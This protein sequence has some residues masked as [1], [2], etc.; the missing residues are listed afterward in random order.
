MNQRTR[1]AGHTPGL[2]RGFTLIEVMI[3]VAIIAILAAI[4]WPAYQNHVTTSNRAAATACLTEH[5]Q[6]MERY[7]TSNLTYENA[8]PDLGCASE[9]R[10]DD[11]YEFNVNNVSR[12]SF[13]LTA[14]PQGVQ[15]TRDTR[16]G[17]LE[18]NHA[19]E[20]GVTGTGDVAG[21]W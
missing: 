13:D 4:A 6:F 5:A 9:G 17:T 14:V 16:C 15:A 7:H 18:L 21:C 2:H 1:K 20:R 10:M 8:D 12:S 11:L 19:G 3:V